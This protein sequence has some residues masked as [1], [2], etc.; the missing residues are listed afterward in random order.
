MTKNQ[1]ENYR[2]VLQDMLGPI[3]LLL[4]D[5][6]VKAHRDMMQKEIDKM[7]EEIFSDDK[8]PTEHSQ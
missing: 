5:E 2:L 7:A 4:S 3:A 8:T 1:I 6:E